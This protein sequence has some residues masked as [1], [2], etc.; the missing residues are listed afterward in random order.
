MRGKR[1]AAVVRTGR[2]GPGNSDSQSGM[3]SRFTPA[4]SYAEAGLVP[5]GHETREL[6]LDMVKRTVCNIIYEDSGLWSYNHTKI[7]HPLNRFELHLRL[8]GEDAPT[9]AHTMIGWHRL[10]NVQTCFAN[11]VQEQVK[12][13]L[14]EAGVLRGGSAIF[15]RALLKAYAI[16]ERRVFVCDTFSDHDPAVSGV[17]LW[18]RRFMFLLLNIATRV[19]SRHC[20]YAIFRLFERLQKHFPRAENPSPEWV[21][22]MIQIIRNL[23]AFDRMARKDTTSLGAVQSHFARYGLLDDQVVFLQGF[24]SDTLPRINTDAI[25]ILRCD[26]DTFESTYGVLRDLYSKVSRGG[27]VILDDYNGFSEC[28][29]AVD[30]FRAE[31]GISDPLVPIDNLAVY[32]NKSGVTVPVRPQT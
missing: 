14:V 17:P 6:Y 11:V 12:G 1:V 21:A 13:D 3:T 15:M 4:T 28:K 30:R 23:D 20:R 10:T 7:F 22:C 18:V 2:E 27:Y 26:G 32:W 16:A 19:P 24:F 31:H 9:Q 29:T 25:A 8:N 5:C